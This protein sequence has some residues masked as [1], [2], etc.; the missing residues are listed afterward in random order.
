MAKKYAKIIKIVE[1]D[2]PKNN[3]FESELKWICSS[4]GIKP[5]ENNLSFSIFLHILAARKNGKGVQSKEIAQRYSI[6]QANVVHHLRMLLRTGLIIKEGKNY[7]L[8][9]RNLEETLDI[10]EN[11]AK[12][13]FKKLKEVSKKIDEKMLW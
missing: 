1:I 5:D 2:D 13:Y 3:D 9:G 12:N 7:I 6:L 10:L 4:L 8:R 11:D